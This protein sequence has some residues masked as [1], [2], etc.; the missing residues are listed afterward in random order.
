MNLL[1]KPASLS[2]APFLRQA[3]TGEKP[4]NIE[5]TFKIHLLHHIVGGK[6]L[7]PND[8]PIAKPAEPRGQPRIGRLGQFLEIRERGRLRAAPRNFVRSV[9][10]KPSLGCRR[11]ACEY[12]AIAR[13]APAE[14]S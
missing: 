13:S 5:R 11:S 2:D 9:H 14:P 8:H 1:G 4:E 7:D 6:I 10:A 3:D 12:R